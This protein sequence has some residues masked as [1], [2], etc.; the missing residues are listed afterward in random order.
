MGRWW[1]EASK[2]GALFLRAQSAGQVP[3]STKSHARRD[4]R[5]VLRS[6]S[7]IRRE[8]KGM[9]RTSVGTGQSG[10][11]GGTRVHGRSP[12]R[13]ER[14]LAREGARCSEKGAG[15]TPKFGGRSLNG[16]VRMELRMRRRQEDA[17]MDGSNGRKRAEQ[18]QLLPRPSRYQI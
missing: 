2:A 4:Q 8:A 1:C 10:R 11:E 9:G 13:L 12:A 18:G 3:E 5:M 14:E 16:A 7:D 6:G 17:R 15:E